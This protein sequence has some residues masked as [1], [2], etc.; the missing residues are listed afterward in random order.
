MRFSR[1]IV[2]RLFY[3]PFKTK[4][5]FDLKSLV[6]PVIQNSDAPLIGLTRSSLSALCS[7][8]HGLEH[9]CSI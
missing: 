7:S 9:V 5:V 1:Y 4:N 3:Q 2:F 8:R 6:K